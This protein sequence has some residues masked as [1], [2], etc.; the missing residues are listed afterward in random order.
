MWEKSGK[1]PTTKEKWP[2]DYASCKCLALTCPPG[3][4]GRFFFKTQTNQHI[5][6]CM[7]TLSTKSISFASLDGN[8]SVPRIKLLLHS[9]ALT[10]EKSNHKGAELCQ[11]GSWAPC[12]KDGLFLASFT[13]KARCDQEEEGE[14][15]MLVPSPTKG[16]LIAGCIPSFQPKSIETKSCSTP[17]CLPHL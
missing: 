12:P 5:R 16:G 4:D 14:V 3:N 7:C 6:Y 9:V 8:A 17:E 13:K 15:F 11:R 2:K 10:A 1:H